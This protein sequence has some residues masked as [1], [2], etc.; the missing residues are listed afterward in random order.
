MATERQPTVT[1]GSRRWCR[2]AGDP[3][4][5][6]VCEHLQTP[7]GHWLPF[8]RWFVGE[9]MRSDLLCP[10]CAEER[11]SGREIATQDLCATCFENVIDEWGDPVGVKGAPEIRRSPRHLDGKVES[12]ELDVGSFADVA[13]A[14]SVDDS[15]FILTDDLRLLR[16]NSWG[17][18]V[19]ELAAIRLGDEPD[20]GSWSGHVRHP[21]L[22]VSHE[23]AFAAVVNDFGQY[24]TVVDLGTGQ[25]TMTLDGGGYHP[26]TVP[27]SATF[28]VHDGR[29]V[30]VHRTAWNRLDVSDPA[31]G[32]LLTERGP[33]A[34]GRDEQRPANY[35][36]YFHGRL[37]L[38]PD[39]SRLLDD[40]WVWHPIGIPTT[41]SLDRWLSDNVWESET[42][43]SRVDLAAR[44]YY[45][46]HGFCWL[47][48]SR[49][50]VEGIGEDDL[51]IVDGV[52]IF[53][54]DEIDGSQTRFRQ[55]IEVH[56]FAGPTGRF[57]ADGD[58]L[59]SSDAS[60]LS[61]W[62]L[63]NG[64]LIDQIRGFEPSAH[65][66]IDRILF[67]ATGSTLRRMCY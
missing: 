20:R 5:H 61:V 6:T 21:K 67:Q 31:D 19:D 56:S 34:Y 44:G 46:N 40:G 58:L 66:R 10:A 49:V 22:H 18:A 63:P 62:D 65:S 50:V 17:L 64:A 32:T 57:F 30:L 7:T 43:T 25:V 45:W 53:D 1:E 59:F 16:V 13:V 3:G 35:L 47:D 24:G 12:L 36:D 29:P 54:L 15:V 39:G 9:G 27:F 55:A 41:W 60:G 33:T 26:E 23:G 52:R 51:D 37:F 42:G 48:E 8:H 11:S 28:A 4:E 38:S 14:R 2:H